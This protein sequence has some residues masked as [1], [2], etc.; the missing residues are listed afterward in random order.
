MGRGILGL[1]SHQAVFQVSFSQPHPFL[2]KL[3]T[4][5]PGRTICSFCIRSDQISRSVVS[6]SLYYHP[7]LALAYLSL[8]VLPCCSAESVRTTLSRPEARPLDGCP[9]DQGCSL[10]A[11]GLEQGLSAIPLSFKFC[12]SLL[13][14]KIICA[15]VDN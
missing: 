1:S 5:C 13:T 2:C 15:I 3:I 11:S 7:N 4:H 9:Q 14:T 12:F 8:Q 6:E 10:F